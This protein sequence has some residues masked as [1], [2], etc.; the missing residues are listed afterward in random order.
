MASKRRN[1]FHKNKTQETTEKDDPVRYLADLLDRCMLFR[2]GIVTQ[3]PP[4]VY[5]ADHI[6][7]MFT[8][9][10]P[11]GTGRITKQQYYKGS[12]TSSRDFESITDGVIK[13]SIQDNAE[14]FGLE[15]LNIA[16]MKTMGIESVPDE[17]SVDRDG[18][19]LKETF[20]FIAMES[21]VDMLR[22]F[23]EVGDEPPRQPSLVDSEDLVPCCYDEEEW[24]TESWGNEEPEECG[25]VGDDAD[26]SEPT[27]VPLHRLRPCVEAMPIKRILTVAA[28]PQAKISSFLVE[29]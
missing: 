21:M 24:C 1:M 9:L 12:D 10:D 4:T 26:V 8:A 20:Q 3:P 19:I 15:G 25:E 7:S 27:P 29:F 2:S 23:I 18:M 14:D 13:G 17:P 11:A 6:A 16:G 22:Q 28:Q 5:T